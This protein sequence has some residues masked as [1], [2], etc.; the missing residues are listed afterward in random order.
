MT[1]Q[2]SKRGHLH[3]R[4][5]GY[6][7]ALGFAGLSAWYQGSGHWGGLAVFGVST[8]AAT[9]CLQ[10]FVRLTHTPGPGSFSVPFMPW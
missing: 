2:R 6:E 7:T 4:K 10:S 3:V 9:A 1:Y 5:D 8:I